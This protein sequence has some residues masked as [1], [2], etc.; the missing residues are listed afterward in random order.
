MTADTVGGGLSVLGWD[1]EWE[2]AMPAGQTPARVIVTHSGAWRVRLDGGEADVRR[3]R[4]DID[5]APTTG[6]WVG[7]TEDT[8]GWVI[9]T[10]LPRRTVLTRATSSESSHEQVLAANAETI[11]IVIP[12]D[13]DLSA[14]RLERFL[15]MA[16]SS[17]AAPVVV[18]SKRDTVDDLA[19]VKA[20][21]ST[22]APGAVVVSISA[23][24]ADGMAELRPH[25]APGRTAALLGTSGAGKSTLVNALAGDEGLA[26]AGTRKDGAG[27]HTTVRRELIVL[28]DHGMLIDT[29]GLRSVGIVDDE[30]LDLVFPEIEELAAH[31]RFAD[32]RHEHEPDCAVKEAA[33]SG[34]VEERRYANYRRLVREAEAAAT[35]RDAGLR[36]AEKRRAKTIERTLRSMPEN[37][38]H[39]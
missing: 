15:A 36:S 8:G 31:C 12:A 25:L 10:L 33:A 20:D 32:C 26:V 35:R 7:L 3:I 38:R 17:G 37:Y 30:A 9:E 18:L 22:A 28:P 39:H 34:A 11:L 27:R 24:E 16:W 2:R 5:A 14:G 19:T 13:V 29:P 23:L 4:P 6:D 1:E 21:I